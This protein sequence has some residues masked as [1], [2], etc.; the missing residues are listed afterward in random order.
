MELGW[1]WLTNTDHKIRLKIKDWHN[2]NIH[3]YSRC[4]IISSSVLAIF[5]VVGAIIGKSDDMQ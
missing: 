4:M 2:K 5:D 3:S 1:F